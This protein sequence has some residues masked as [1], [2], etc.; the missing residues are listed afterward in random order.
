MTIFKN[1]AGFLKMAGEFKIKA[2]YFDDSIL[3]IANRFKEG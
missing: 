3:N 2:L 1:L